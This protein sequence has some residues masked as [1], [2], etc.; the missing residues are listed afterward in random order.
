[1]ATSSNARLAPVTARD[2]VDTR[3][4][5]NSVMPAGGSGETTS[6]GATRVQGGQT[7]ASGK[8]VPTHWLLRV[9]DGDHFTSSQRYSRW[10]INS[11]HIAWVPSFLRKVRRGDVIWFIQSESGGKVMGVATF[12]HHCPRV[13]GPLIALTPTNDDLGWTKTEGYWDTE[14]HYTDLY[15]LSAIPR[16]LLTGIKSPLVGRRYNP[17]K[18]A[19][20]LPTEYGYVTRYLHAK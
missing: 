11:K 12:S 3:N 6:T 10:G 18:C 17:A 20:D 1:M 13:T 7:A 4:Q 8:K 16:P 5:D 19:V 14:V 2:G 15:D 9:G